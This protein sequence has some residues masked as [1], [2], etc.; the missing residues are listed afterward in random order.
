MIPELPLV[1]FRARILFLLV[2]LHL[3]YVHPAQVATCTVL[4]DGREVCSSANEDIEIDKK[5]TEGG[6]NIRNKYT[7]DNEMMNAQDLN[8]DDAMLDF[9]EEDDDY[10]GDFDDANFDDDDYNDEGIDDF[11]SLEEDMD[12][13]TRY[14]ID[15]HGSCQDTNPNQCDTSA[16]SGLCATNPSL[17]HMTCP[18]SCILCPDQQPPNQMQ[19]DNTWRNSALSVGLLPDFEAYEVPTSDSKHDEKCVDDDD[20]CPHWA[21]HGECQNNPGYMLV[22]CPKS[23]NQCPKSVVS[24]EIENRSRAI[25]DVAMEYGTG[26]WFLVKGEPQTCAGVK[27][28]ETIEKLKE[29]MIY[30]RDVIIPYRKYDKVRNDCVNRNTNCAFWAVIGQC[31]SN[32]DYMAHECAPSC[33]TCHLLLDIKA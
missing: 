26:Y 2:L 28:L 17:M 32:T 24:L 22:G 7:G 3:G 14:E 16:G 27:K 25:Y 23:C 4:A 11:S 31:E 9:R 20:R 10:E 21:E 18:R 29:T 19:E 13:E 1:P 15:S 8:D 33:Q 30:L 12:Y 5:I 6:F